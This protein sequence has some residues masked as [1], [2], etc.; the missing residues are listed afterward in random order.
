MGARSPDDALPVDS[1]AGRVYFTPC[2]GSVACFG[3]RPKQI[4]SESFPC[5]APDSRSLGNVRPCPSLRIPS[6]FL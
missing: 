2:D 1:N 3:V 6:L 4:A 5:T